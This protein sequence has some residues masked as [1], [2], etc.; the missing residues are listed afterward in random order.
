M[1]VI[2]VNQ[3]TKRTAS[4]E[5]KF[6]AKAD[7]K[8][9]AASLLKIV[10]DLSTKKIRNRKLLG[11]KKEITIVF[12][13][14]ADMKKLN[15]QFRKKN[16]PTDILSFPSHDPESLGELL[17]CPEV[18]QRQAREHRHSVRAETIYMLI[19][20]VLHLL[21][22]DHEQSKAEERLMFRIQDQCFK[23]LEPV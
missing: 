6:P 23:T 4:K 15:F 21:G 11:Q 1:K 14:T 19:H 8:F 13:S 18:L 16:K 5:R 7:E 3:T 17:L 10:N 20:G 9:I 2:Q 22:Y 12:L